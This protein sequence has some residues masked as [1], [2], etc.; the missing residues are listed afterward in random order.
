MYYL[1]LFLALLMTAAVFGALAAMIV[2]QCW[3][4]ATARDIA[5]AQKKNRPG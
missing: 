2:R 3:R 4:W 1:P 5:R